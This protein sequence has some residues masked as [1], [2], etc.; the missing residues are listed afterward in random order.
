MR[1][2]LLLLVLGFALQWVLPWWILAIAAFVLAF[3]LAQRA[4]DAFWAGFGGIGLGWLGLSLFFHLR[5]DG[6]LTSRVATLFTLP[7]SWLLLVVTALLGGL[8]G[9]LAALSGYF[10]RRALT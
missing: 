5:N 7:Q 2:F 8:V 4:G 3:W 9:G 6:L 1:L 10:C